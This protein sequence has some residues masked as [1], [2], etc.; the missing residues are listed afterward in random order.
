MS[1]FLNIPQTIA[2]PTPYRLPCEEFVD[3]KY[4]LAS[5]HDT[6]TTTDK[7]MNCGGKPI[8]VG[9]SLHYSSAVRP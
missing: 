2:Q 8:A 4:K 3:T 9:S 7:I 1:G 5:V 6:G